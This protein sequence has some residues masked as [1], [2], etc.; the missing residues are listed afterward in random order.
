MDSFAIV[1]N[2]IANMKLKNVFKKEQKTVRF[3][4]KN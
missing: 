3:L 2:M 4:A 1:L